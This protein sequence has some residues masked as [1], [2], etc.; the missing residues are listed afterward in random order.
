MACSVGG[1]ESGWAVARLVARGHSSRRKEI[2]PSGP[3]TLG[4]GLNGDSA[5]HSAPLG[6]AHFAFFT[7]IQHL[8]KRWSLSQGRGLGLPL[9]H[10]TIDAVSCATFAAGQDLLPNS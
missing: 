9:M 2:R 10:T 7:R 6:T 5:P 4:T 1:V 8:L 3:A